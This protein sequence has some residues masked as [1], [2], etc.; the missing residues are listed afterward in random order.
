MRGTRLHESALGKDELGVTLHEVHT[1]D[2]GDSGSSPCK[3]QQ[4]RPFLLAKELG[5]DERVGAAMHCRFEVLWFERGERLEN[6]DEGV[7]G[8]EVQ[9]M[10]GA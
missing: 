4:H 6:L 2:V 10:V 9:A 7:A 1:L 8:G 5:D 3:P